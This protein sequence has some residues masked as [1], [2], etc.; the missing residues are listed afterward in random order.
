MLTVYRRSAVSERP[1]ESGPRTAPPPP[2]PREPSG[3][4][5]SLMGT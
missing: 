2:P 5:P 1:S 4:V 3:R